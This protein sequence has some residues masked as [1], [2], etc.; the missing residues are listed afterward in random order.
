MKLLPPFPS[1]ILFSLALLL[2]TSAMAHPL[3]QTP[4]VEA[5]SSKGYVCPPCN[6][7]CDDTV[8]A[9]PGVCPTCSMPL[10][11]VGSKDAE[12]PIRKKVAI[13]IFNGVEIID[14]M[15]PYEMFGAADCDVYTVAA[16]KDPVTSAMG[17]TILPTRTFAD[18]PQPDVLVIPGGAVEATG[19]SEATLAYIKQAHVH[20]QYTMS[21]CNGAFILANTGLLD[22]LNVT[23]TRGNIPRLTRQ[24]PKLHVVNDQRY[25]DNGKII[26]TGG[27]SAGIDGALHVIEKLFG[28]EEAQS[29]A[30]QEEYNWQPGTKLLSTAAKKQTPGTTYVCPMKEHTQVFTKPGECTLCHMKLV[31]KAGPNLSKKAQK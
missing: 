22:G 23:T 16:S 24:Y 1:P 15:G 26:T 4:K 5:A 31:P 21:V 12:A 28:V 9:Q 30:R 19:K 2:G 20:T 17:L 3:N 27:L 14:S 11:P 25:T 18:A 13:L 29:V 10:V 6:T 8:H 7:P